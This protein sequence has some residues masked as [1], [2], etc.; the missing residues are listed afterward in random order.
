MV[1]YRFST[2]STE[3]GRAEDLAMSDRTYR[4]YHLCSDG[5]IRGAVNRSFTDD[6]EA[7]AHAGSLLVSHP[8]VEVWQTDRLVGRVEQA[9]AQR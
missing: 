2:R 7:I 8:A 6:A 4:L 9:R 1:F 3:A 5:R